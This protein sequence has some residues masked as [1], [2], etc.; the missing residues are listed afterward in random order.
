[1]KV[2]QLTETLEI[3]GQER[4]AVALA[5][6]LAASCEVALACMKHSGPLAG[7]LDERVELMEFG[8]GEGNSAAAVWKLSR[9]IRERRIEALHSHDWGVFL[10]GAAAAMLAGGV[11]HVLTI[12][13]AYMAYPPGAWAGIK[14][15]LR[16]LA[17]RATLWFDTTI[18]CVSEEL[19]EQVCREVGVNRS[20]VQVI[21]NGVGDLPLPT[22]AD[23][24]G[25]TYRFICVGRLA[26]VKNLPMLI[27]AFGELLRQGLD[28]QLDIVGDGPERAALERQVA[29]AGIEASRVRF[30]GF[31][32]DVAGLLATAD[33]FVLSSN[34]EGMPMAVLE[35]MQSGLPVIATRVGGVPS[36]VQDGVTGSLVRPGDSRQ[37]A[38][39]MRSLVQDP[40]SALRAGLCGASRV[41]ERFSEQAMLAAYTRLYCG[42][43]HGFCGRGLA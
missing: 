24:A 3:G 22:R 15:R 40:G 26:T 38:E 34:S 2:M 37:L 9:A 23:A 14:K 10:D 25:R 8:K 17:E 41:R 30:L 33:A 6:Q 42:T 27:D 11:R 36:L 28:T 1:M 39:A 43:G 7:G 32:P 4:L 19:A 18:V 21:V 12:H 29:S 35:A 13:G 16:H 20:R 5:N 31:R